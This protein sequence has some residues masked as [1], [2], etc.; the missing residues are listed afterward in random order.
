MT[1]TIPQ[2]IEL[3]VD[4]LQFLNQRLDTKDFRKHRIITTKILRTQ[5]E[6][7]RYEI[8]LHTIKVM[9]A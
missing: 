5:K 6:I 8:I 4:R 2:E 7:K 9:R 1:N 3:L